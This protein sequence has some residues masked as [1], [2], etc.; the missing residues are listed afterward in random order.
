MAIIHRLNCHPY[1][2]LMIYADDVLL[3]AGLDHDL[4]SVIRDIAA[5]ITSLTQK[6]I[7]LIL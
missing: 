7:Y 6:F 5:V 1:L 2:K 3:V 4:D